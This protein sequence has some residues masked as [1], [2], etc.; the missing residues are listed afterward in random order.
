MGPWRP[1]PRRHALASPSGILETSARGIQPPLPPE[2]RRLPAKLSRPS[3]EPRA[4]RRRREAAVTRR[5]SRARRPATGRAPGL[6]RPARLPPRTPSRRPGSGCGASAGPTM[7]S[8]SHLPH[9]RCSSCGEQFRPADC[10]SSFESKKDRREY[11]SALE[12]GRKITGAQPQ[13]CVSILL[14]RLPAACVLLF[15]NPN[16]NGSQGR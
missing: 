11:Y 13:T 6:R 7:P 12:P 16:P 10:P 8:W 15:P 2:S 1:H 5:R 3:P 4:R 14:C 9:R